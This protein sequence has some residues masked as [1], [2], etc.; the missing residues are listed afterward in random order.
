MDETALRAQFDRELEVAGLALTGR[1]RDLFYA[2]WKDFHPQREALRAAV[3]A[4]DDEP[5]R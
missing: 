2:M 3:P 4:P 5:L 1:E